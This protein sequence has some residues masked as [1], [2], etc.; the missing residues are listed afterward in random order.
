MGHVFALTMPKGGVGKTTTAQ[1]LGVNLG[2]VG[3]KVLLIDLD[4]Q[5]NLSISLGINL[6]ELEYSVYDVLHNPKKGCSFAVIGTEY[7]VDILPSKIDLAGAELDF[8]GMTARESLLK[9]A[10]CKIVDQYDYILIDAPPTLGLF[11]MNAMTAADVVIVPLQLQVYAF[12]AAMP[13]LEAGIDVIRER[14]NPDIEIGG[15]VGTMF[16]AR[17][18]L[19][20]SVDRLARE[21]YGDVVFETVIPHSTKLAESPAAGQPISVYDPD[22]AASI[23]YAKLTREVVGRYGFK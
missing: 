10:M 18:N 19:S 14:L 12:K 20:K 2:R 1:N 17:T 11:S 8:A 5:A 15:I 13:Q 16:D 9:L 21:K 4:P 23:A 7:D 22:G 6:E 3:A